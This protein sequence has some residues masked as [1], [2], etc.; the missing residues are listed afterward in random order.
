MNLK[1]KKQQLAMAAMDAAGG[2]DSSSPG[3]QVKRASIK[4]EN[5]ES[6]A[7]RKSLADG[8][9]MS[10]END[11]LKTTLMILTQKL[12]LREDD[13]QGQEERW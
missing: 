1:L 5:G 10:I 11:R 13:S 3:K 8:D 9:E 12:K 7:G 4:F 6:P 2:S